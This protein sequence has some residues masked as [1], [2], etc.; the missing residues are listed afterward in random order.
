MQ[1]RFGIGAFI[2]YLDFKVTGHLFHRCPDNAYRKLNHML[3]GTQRS[4]TERVVNGVLGEI[5][6]D[7]RVIE[8]RIIR[9]MARGY[10]QADE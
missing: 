5:D 8:S 10:T 4:H 1:R 2:Y 6:V 3:C 7:N 9:F